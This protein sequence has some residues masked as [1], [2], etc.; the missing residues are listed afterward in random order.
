MQTQIDIRHSGA[1]PAVPA[2]GLTSTSIYALLAGAVQAGIDLLDAMEAAQDGLEDDEREG[3]DVDLEPSL[4]A[5]ERHPSLPPGFNRYGPF[6]SRHV[7]DKQTEWAAG[8]RGV[9]GD[10]REPSLGS[11][12]SCY[13]QT[14]P[15]TAWARGIHND[16]EG[17]EHDGAEPDEDAS[18]ATLGATHALNQEIAW[19]AGGGVLWGSHPSGEDEPSLGWSHGRGHPE[20]VPFGGLDD[21]EEQHD[22]E[23]DMAEWGIA[24][25]DALAIEL[26]EGGGDLPCLDQ[27]AE[28]ASSVLSA[29]RRSVDFATPEAAIA[30]EQVAMRNAAAR[31]REVVV[32][33][34]AAG[35]P[36]SD[37]LPGVV[38]IVGPAALSGEFARITRVL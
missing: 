24:D 7:N 21:R 27:S 23:S 10:D 13:G 6:V 16:G 14:T 2:T 4:G 37:P 19:A 35:E 26:A 12:G 20:P 22:R 34:R 32:R 30:R 33:I 17:D 11:I 1:D 36:Q 3:T 15:Q 5:P 31:L 9:D 8:D 18:D 25:N 28:G 38:E 29:D